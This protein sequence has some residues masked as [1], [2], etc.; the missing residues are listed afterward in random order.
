M[1]CWSHF[2][3]DWSD[4][5]KK[6]TVYQG[7]KLILPVVLLYCSLFHLLTQIIA[8][9]SSHSLPYSLSHSLIPLLAQS[10][11]CLRA[12]PTTH[13]LMHAFTASASSH[14]QRDHWRGWPYL[15]ANTTVP[16]SSNWIWYTHCPGYHAGVYK[17]VCVTDWLTNKFVCQTKQIFGFE[18][19]NGMKIKGRGEYV[20]CCHMTQWPN[21]GSR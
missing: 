9:L 12:R 11:A 6:Q 13:S 1:I 4:R 16:S 5:P 17:R 14:Q 3:D 19:A 18:G 21:R 15:P 8:R 20:W 7:D 10:L 2:L